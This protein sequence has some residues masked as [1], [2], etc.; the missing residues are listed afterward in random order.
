MHMEKYRYSETEFLL[1]ENSCIPFAVY[2]FIDNRVVTIVL[3]KG[4][5]DVFGFDDKEEAYF[6]MDNDMYRHAHP[7]DA[8]RIA[9]AA[10]SFATK[11]GE[12]DV[13]YRTMACGEYKIIHAMGEHVYTKDGTRLAVIWYTDEGRY[14]D[15]D[16]GYESSLNRS[17]SLE[18]HKDSLYSRMFY[19]H[20]TGLPSMSY[21]LELAE[22]GRNRMLEKGETPVFLY[23]DLNRFKL[24]NNKYGYAEGDRLLKAFAGILKK[25][26]SNE[27]CGRFGADHFAVFTN[28]EGLEDKLNALFKEFETANGGRTLPVRA[29]IYTE[30]Q[31]GTDIA[32]G[33]DRAK[34]ACDTDKNTFVSF[35]R[36]FDD[37][38][39]ADARRNQYILGNFERALKEEWIQVYYQPIV[40]AANG[41]VCDEEALSRWI[42]PH[43]GMIMPSE[44]IPVLEDAGLIYKLDLYVLEKVI[45]KSMKQREMGYYVV[46]VSV[47]LSRSDFEMCDMVNEVVSRVD[48]A[49]LS[50]EKLTIEITE[51]MVGQ[52]F[53]YM[54]QQVEMF[55]KLGFK[56]WM[57]DFGSEYSSLD[58]LQKTSVDLIKLDLH[59]MERFEDG[60]RTKLIISEMIKMAIALGIDTVAEGVETEEQANFLKEVGCT[61]LQGYYYC[62]PIPF[63]EIIA[64]YKEGRSIGFENPAESDYYSEV[65]KINLYDVSVVA[66]AETAMGRYFDT[67]PMAVFEAEPDIIK[68][69]RCNRAYRTF[70]EKVFGV[71]DDGHGINFSSVD[72]DRNSAFI[73]A[74]RQA[75]E[76]GQNILIDEKFNENN[77]VHAMVRKVAENPVTGITACVL[78]VL[79][80]MDDTS[81][82]K[83]DTY[84]N[85]AR[86]LSSDYVYLYYVNLDDDT[87]SEYSHDP[88][89]G[90]LSVERH[91]TDFFGQS[92]RDAQTLIYAADRETF[93]ERFTKEN[94]IHY[95][96]ENNT[97]TL[98]YRLLVD[99]NP[100]YVAMKIVRVKSDGNYIIIGVNNID[101]QM[102]H[103]ETVERLRA[104][105]I[106]YSRINALAGDFIAI[107]TVDPES[108]S[109]LEYSSTQ[110]Y[111]GLGIAKSGEDFYNTSRIESANVIYSGDQNMFLNTFTKRNILNDIEKK[112]S[113][114]FIYRLM[115]DD[116]PTFVLLRAAMI[117]EKDGPQIIFGV[118]NIDSRMRQELRYKEGLNEARRKANTDELTGVNNK[119]AYTACEAELNRRI[120]LGEHPEFAIVILDINDLKLVNDTLGH[121]EGDRHIRMCCGEICD[122][123]DR[124]SVYRI[125]GDEFAV[126][127]KDEECRSV[128]D[129]VNKLA[130]L[131]LRNVEDKGPVIACGMAKYSTEAN[132]AEVFAKADEQMYQ[133]KKLLK[134]L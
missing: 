36:Y 30:S 121:Q 37:D 83:R 21:F 19:D 68:L 105:R 115:I 52:D 48:A 133:N 89:K 109:Y 128:N 10:V 42:D 8:A 65:G 92:K 51:S 127:V 134:E 41:R 120:E 98:S 9:D 15:D 38:M 80:I 122:L 69:T 95:L 117:E 11:G 56:V 31:D 12:Y 108:D 70:A 123:F 94:I 26:Y 14:S 64:R 84:A 7:D 27:N 74:V 77:S 13:V 34:Y 50:H 107:Y 72:L 78:V 3:S 93:L 102:R 1:M 6:V 125:G 104:E 100:V 90:D 54:K 25:Y 106:T 40:R 2:Q 91:G 97:F 17:M 87:F 46:P 44:F 39:L 16:K 99:G 29:G 23:F 82:I 129:S 22:A 45:A 76:S 32:S 131:N 61:K 33:C 75:A 66:N 18:L 58:M 63:E 116:K 96:D 71:A 130:R 59:F 5:M 35:F 132:V 81:Q 49:G 53:D 112:G 88:E 79:G 101:T 20:L 67:F 28:S 85:I 4:F 73:K 111:E 43:R 119:R 110:D 24:F 62:R 118:T 57:D 124:D 47:N 126:V 113:F 55:H 60:E 103:Q 114:E 86:A